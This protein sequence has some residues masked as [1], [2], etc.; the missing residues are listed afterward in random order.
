[1]RKIYFLGLIFIV[2]VLI[3]P[4]CGPAE[5]NYTGREYMMDMGHSIA[6]EANVSNYYSYNRFESEEDY[7]DMIQPRSPQQGTIPRGYAG[8]S[9]PADAAGMAAFRSE[10]QS[11]PINGSVPY[12]YEDTPEDRERAKAEII[13]NPF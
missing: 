3:T 5:G 10:F 11:H 6:Y 8:L 9:N 12:Y 7:Y 4:A 1:M 2:V 13:K